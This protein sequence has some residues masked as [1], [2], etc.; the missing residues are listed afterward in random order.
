MGG[1][2]RLSQERA[3]E[4]DTVEGGVDGEAEEGEENEAGID[5]AL[6]GMQG[7]VQQERQQEP[8]QAAH[9]RPRTGGEKGMGPDVEHHDTPQRDGRERIHGRLRPLRAVGPAGQQRPGKER[10]GGAG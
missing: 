7:A 2:P 4:G 8:E 10:Q 9:H 5:I 3:E 6:P 1:Y